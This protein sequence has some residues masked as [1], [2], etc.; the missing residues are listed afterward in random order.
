M[1]NPASGSDSESTVGIGVLDISA[2]VGGS[3]HS[4][5]GDFFRFLRIVQRHSVVEVLGVLGPAGVRLPASSTLGHSAQLAG[6]HV[7]LVPRAGGEVSSAF[8][9]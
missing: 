7:P 8:C 9:D 4:G 6:Q 3:L 2:C 5:I 1:T